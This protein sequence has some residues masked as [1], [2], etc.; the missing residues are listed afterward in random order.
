MKNYNLIYRFLF[1]LTALTACKEDD[2]MTMVDMPSPSNLTVNY[3]IANDNTGTLTVIPTA[4]GVS[5]YEI[6]F[7]DAENEQATIIKQGG[8][9]K[10]VYSEGTFSLKIVG[11][12]VNGETIEKIQE[13]VISFSPPEEITSNITIS[14]RSIQVSPV[15]KGATLFEVYFGENEN[16]QAVQIMPGETASY[17]YGDIG[18]YSVKIVAFGAGAATA[19]LEEEVIITESLE[20]PITFEAEDITYKFIDFEGAATEIIANPVKGGINESHMVAKTTKTNGAQ[21]YAGTIFEVGTPLDLAAFKKLK[22][23]VYSPKAGITVRLKLENAVDGSIA[24]EVD[25]VTSQ[26]NEWENL[27]FDLTGM[28]SGNEYA[29]IILFFDFGNPGDDTEYLFDDI[30]LTNDGAPAIDLP[31]DFESSTI[32][33]NFNN[34]GGAT[35]SVINNSFPES[36]NSSGKIAKLVKSSGSEIWAGSSI[37]LSAPIDF[38]SNKIFKLKTYAPQSGITIKLKVENSA[39]GTIAHEV[40]AINSKADEWE[41][42]TYDFSDIDLSKEYDVF[43]IF[44]DFGENGAGADYYFDDVTLTDGV[45]ELKLPL[46]FESASLEYDFTDFDGGQ[47]M[48]IDNPHPAGINASSKVAEMVKNPGQT[49]GGSFITLDNSI[50]FN[51]RK[52]FKMKVYAPRIGVKVL[53]K[54]ENLNNGSISYEREVATT[55]AN[56]WEELTFDYSQINSAES[57]Q[58]VVLIFENGTPGDGST[59]FTYFF[60]DILLTN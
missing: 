58:K 30:S 22:V 13:I 8:K 54:V 34:F 60:D 6:F 27:L 55:V 23:K 21:T 42:L 45:D 36:I 41:E 12:G 29:K 32:P 40:D 31:L 7:G 53:L 26:Q 17:I 16:E 20:L 5:S 35:T 49:W 24:A 46:S 37:K 28:D 2:E 9:A 51:T 50:D 59:D 10:H 39:D 56:D 18:T 43:V 47:V 3:E 33:Y 1:L 14:N 15:A 48:V 52:T 19:V 11:K 38:S 44:F 57:Y 25:A 4:E